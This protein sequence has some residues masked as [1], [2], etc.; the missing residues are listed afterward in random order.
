MHPLL[1]GL[2][3]TVFLVGVEERF[4]GLLFV[5]EEVDRPVDLGEGREGVLFGFGRGFG[6]NRTPWLCK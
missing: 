4:I 5:E 1:G 3:E 6:V 2:L